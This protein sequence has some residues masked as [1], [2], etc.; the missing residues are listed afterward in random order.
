MSSPI[1]FAF[2][3][4]FAFLLLL[5]LLLLTGRSIVIPIKAIILS[6]LSVGAAYGIPSGSSSTGTCRGFAASS[7]AE[8]QLGAALPLHRPHATLIRGVLPAT[9]KLL[10]DWNSYLP[11]WLEWL[12]RLGADPIGPEPR[13]KAPVTP[14]IPA[15]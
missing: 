12:P 9:M 4:G 1:V 14:P 13:E 6:L 3:L 11:R 10:G 15:V 8:R 5:L 7:R 2:V